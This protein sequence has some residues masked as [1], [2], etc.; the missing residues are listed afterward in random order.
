MGRLEIPVSQLLSN[1]S[2][3]MV[4]NGLAGIP[5]GQLWPH[6]MALHHCLRTDR[7]LPAQSAY[8]R[9]CGISAHCKDK[10]LGVDLR[11]LY[12]SISK[13]GIK[14][15]VV[16]YDLDGIYELVGGHH[17]AMCAYFLGCDVPVR[18]KE[19]DPLMRN[20][21]PSFV[22]EAYAA[23]EQHETLSKGMS[24][25]PFPGRSHIRGAERMRLI[26]RAIMD[27]RGTH[28]LDAGCN[29]GYFGVTFGAHA[30]TTTFLDKSNLYLDV[31]RAKLKAL[32]QGAL[33]IN[34]T[35]EDFQ[36]PNFDVVLYTDVFYHVMI[37][38]SLDAAMN[39][40]IKLLGMTDDRMIFSPGRWDKLETHGFTETLLW[41]T[42]ETNGF[43]IRLLGYDS[44]KNYGRPLFCL[45][46]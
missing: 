5:V 9:L 14:E 21:L 10:G 46:R 32:D 4:V 17:R 28:L 11:K 25:N 15:P 19:F 33:T 8:T 16:V 29:D 1:R 27:T 36:H 39:D 40:W 31:V 34:A 35:I 23:V 18:F 37:R 45:E 38:Q 6:A 41:E 24:Y 13:E 12:K 2:P 3:F 22:E 43:R 26:Y 42:A 7:P 30:F 20:K 44:D